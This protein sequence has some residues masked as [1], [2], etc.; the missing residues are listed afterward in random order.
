M[1]Y[2]IT[3]EAKEVCPPL[4]V[5]GFSKETLIKFASSKAFADSAPGCRREELYFGRKLNTFDCELLHPT[6]E[7]VHRPVLHIGCCVHRQH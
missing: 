3:G 5:N 6:Q 2:T 7:G 1:S 4:M